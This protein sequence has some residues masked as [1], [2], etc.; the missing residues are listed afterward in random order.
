MDNKQYNEALKL[1]DGYVIDNGEI[2][3]LSLAFPLYYNIY[4]NLMLPSKDNL[5]FSSAFITLLC[6]FSRPLNFFKFYIDL[7][8]EA[9]QPKIPMNIYGINILKSG[10][11]KGLTNNI[12]KGL[13]NF[14]Y[15]KNEFIK[16]L[17]KDLDGDNEDEDIKK[18][19]NKLCNIVDAEEQASA[20]TAGMRVLYDELKNC[21]LNID[22]AEDK[23]VG[24]AF[25]NL[26]ELADSLENANNYDKDFFSTLKELYDLGEFSAKSLKTG[27]M[28]NMRKFY[29]SFL[30]ATTDKTLQNNPRTSRLLNNFF[31]SG[32]ARRSLISMP[33]P[34]EVLLVESM[35]KNT[36]GMTLRELFEAKRFVENEDV[37][38]TREQVR[39]NINRLAYKARV[40]QKGITVTKDCY[41]YYNVYKWLCA[42]RAKKV[43]SSILELET[44]NRFWKAL[45][46]SGLLAI[47]N[48][49]SQISEEYFCEA[50]KIVE[51]YSYH[52]KRCLNNRIMTVNDKIIELLMNN[53]NNGDKDKVCGI[54]NEELRTNN[55]VNSYRENSNITSGD[56]VKKAM[57]EVE[58][59]LDIAGYTLMKEKRGYNNKVTVYA[60]IPNDWLNPKMS[61]KEPY[62][63][64]DNVPKGSEGK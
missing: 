10:G 24:G 4:K 20:S 29:V 53:N 3:E 17:G 51:Y 60:A 6:Q 18:N 5:C 13:L 49:E 28:G 14:D 56:F 48:G 30:G 34:Q 37:I 44:E 50:V 62:V 59:T 27:I 8:Q 40:G 57:K 22:L 46:I 42:D 36:D 16:Q 9:N 61:D 21:F 55:E 43:S 31:I 35:K 1:F 32:H 11:G 54:T 25:F 15:T 39:N 64:W 52:F 58:E 45:K 38:K 47:Y 19:I 26:Q 41:F 2:T 63:V 23:W 12:V 7:E 33:S